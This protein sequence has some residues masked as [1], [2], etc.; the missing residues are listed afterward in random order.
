MIRTLITLGLYG[1]VQ[2]ALSKDVY[3]DW[4]IT[5]VTA[6]PDGYARPVIGINGHWPCPQIDV[7][8]GDNLIVD[9]YNG[10]GNESTGIHWHGLHQNYNGYMDGV[11]GVTQ[12]ELHPNQRMRYIV[13]MNQTGTYWYHSHEPG[14]YPDGLRGPIIVHDNVPKPYH[15]DEEM[16]LTLSDWYHVQI[17]VLLD[18]FIVPGDHAPYGGLEPLPDAILF[19]DMHN[20]KI[21]VK[22]GTTYLIHVVCM[23]NFP[24]HALVIDDHDMT[25]VGMDGIAVEPHFLQPQYLRVAV[26]QRVDILLTTKNDTSKNYAIWDGLDI[27]EMFVQEGRSPPQGY[28]PNGTAW[29]MYNEDAPLPPA[30]IIHVNNASLD[31]L[32]DVTLKPIDN[33][34]LIDPIQHQFIFDVYPTTVD[35]KPAYSINNMTYNAPD[36]PTLY[37]AIYSDPEACL[38]PELYGDVNPFVVNY[39]DVVEIVLNNH[40]DNLHPW[41][42]HGHDFQVL[43]RTYPY[44]G[45]F[46]G[47]RNVSATP[48]RRDTLMVEPMGHFVIRFRAMNPGIWM[49]HCHIEW[50]VEIRLMAIIIEAPDQLQNMTIPDDHLKICGN[51]Q[52]SNWAPLAPSP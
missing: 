37:T 28:N 41:H 35:G 2:Q 38:D 22:P 16:T 12:C 17:P 43:Q 29:L 20:T 32:D 34:P 50:H 26:G 46:D 9:V 42:L 15:Y 4:N 36:S 14:Q 3:L 8:V 5:W 13:P 44:G 40:H 21:S 47:Y 23:G 33:L 39:G 24:G 11:P 31:F 51:T 7:D 27:D 10:L 6:A 30:P 25:I 52:P 1:F 48:M 49:F 45:F 19:N 18:Q